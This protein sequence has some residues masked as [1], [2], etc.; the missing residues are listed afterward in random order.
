MQMEEARF[1]EDLPEVD[2]KGYAVVPVGEPVAITGTLQDNPIIYLDILV[3]YQ[4]SKMELDNDDK[5]C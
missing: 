4:I 1:I 2:A 3:A 5:N